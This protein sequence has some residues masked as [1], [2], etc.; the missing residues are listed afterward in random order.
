[1]LCSLNIKKKKWFWMTVIWYK[2][3]SFK[4]LKKMYLFLLLL[5]IKCMYE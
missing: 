1:M 5:F 2:H 3:N 4:D